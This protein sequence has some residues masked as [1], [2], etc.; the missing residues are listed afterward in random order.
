MS[1]A[2]TAAAGG[3]LNH[4]VTE[5][6]TENT[7]SSV[8]SVPSS[9]S[10][11]VRRTPAASRE[12]AGTPLAL[13]DDHFHPAVGRFVDAGAGGDA[14]VALAAAG[15]AGVAHRQALLDEGRAHLDG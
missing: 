6:G 1:A 12:H 3:L 4:G 2:S 5:E 8:T 15:D 9:V 14:Q 10:S 7:E 11:V 13:P